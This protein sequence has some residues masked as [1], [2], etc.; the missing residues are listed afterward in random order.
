MSGDLLPQLDDPVPVF[1]LPNLV[2]FPRAVQF[3]HIFEKRY[4][5]M[6]KHLLERE[7][8]QRLIAMAH[9]R[10][11]YHAKY[12]TNW[13]EIDPIACVALVVKHECLPDGRY[14]LLI[15]GLCRARVQREI[16]DGAYRLAWLEGLR[17]D[18][19]PCEPPD[20]IRLK[21]ALHQALRKPVLA[22]LPCGQ[23]CRDL[24]DSDLHLGAL[25]DL[26]A[27]HLLPQEQDAVK[28]I[29]LEELDMAGRAEVLLKEIQAFGRK[30]EVA[31]RTTTGWPPV[32]YAN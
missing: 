6:C 19:T 11:G 13:A 14:N 10:P 32:N 3:L 7:G 4:R 22:G 24:F 5:L 26:L 27:F 31:S 12:H 16:R 21:E 25:A 2:L 28:Q 17:E 8:D 23:F 30:L 20:H 1:P 9:L 29:M 18:H 15:R